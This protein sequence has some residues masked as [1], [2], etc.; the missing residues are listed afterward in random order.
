MEIGTAISAEWLRDLGALKETASAFD[1]AGI[2]FLSWGGHVL[3]SRE[4]RYDRPASTY[5]EVFRDFFVLSAA[6]SASTT[7]IRFLSGIL[8]LPMFPTVLVAKQAADASL[9]SGGRIEVGVGI[10]W[11][12]SEYAAMGQDLTTRGRRLEEQLVVLKMLWSEPFVT[13]HG[14]FHDIDDFGIGQLPSTPIPIWVGCGSGDQS[15]SRVGRL[16]NGWMPI[17][18]PPKERIDALRA[19]ATEAGRAS[20]PGVSGRVTARLD[21]AESVIA[22]AKALIEVGVT[23][24]SIRPPDGVDIATGISSV[25]ATK[26]TLAE[27]FGD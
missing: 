26:N 10:S 11:N 22:D 1:D 25:I 18:P 8:I 19:F 7:R 5:A 24:I 27:A 4:G 15:L 21:D 2:D 12:E 13:F 6:L 17:A 3:T 23:T 14:R 20:A 9:L 16:A